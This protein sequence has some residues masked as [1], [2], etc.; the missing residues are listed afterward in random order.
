MLQ[1][2]K[3]TPSPD[4]TTAGREPMTDR[5]ESGG[6]SV[7]T[8]LAGAAA[9]A[10]LATA[11]DSGAESGA[12]L[13][14]QLP[15]T[16]S[17]V[18]LELFTSQGCSS[19]PPAER[20]LSRL[21]LGAETRGAVVPLA[22]HVDYWNYLG[23]AD[24]F[25][26]R[27]W[28]ERQG[29]YVR[30]LGI[31]SAYTP[32]LVVNGQRELNGALGTRVL[33]EIEAE[34]RRPPPGRL[35]LET[36]YDPA[37][38]RLTADVAAEIHRDVAAGRLHVTLALFESGIVTDV[39]RGENAGRSLANDFI[40]RRLRR[41]F[42]VSPQ[43]GTRRR[44]VVAFELEGSWEPTNVGLAALL[45]DPLSMRIYGAAVAPAAAQTG[46]GAP[47]PTTSVR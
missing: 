10:V 24:P 41:A 12:P 29:D 28:S 14:A 44:G 23:W 7:R 1:R 16:G 26:A 18:V 38:R 30:A 45:Q 25:S 34:R 13:G 2:N 27:E 42:A 37:R 6:R 46:G 36:R 11:P 35:H 33:E 32:Q 39:P 20:V 47:M 31:R 17:L 19:C 5:E 43:A 8:I 21:G 40:V 3:Q 15:E 4:L 22:F 9:V